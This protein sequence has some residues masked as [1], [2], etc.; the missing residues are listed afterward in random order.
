M[1]K[2][3]YIIVKFLKFKIEEKILKVVRGK[4][5]IIYS[6]IIIKDGWFFMRNKM[7][8]NIME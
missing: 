1:I 5:Y 2:F 7:G 4:R 3:R 6:G 8:Y